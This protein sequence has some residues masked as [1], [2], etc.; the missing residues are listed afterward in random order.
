V[1]VPNK[2]GHPSLLPSCLEQALPLSSKVDQADTACQAL[3]KKLQV[4][5][6]NNKNR[7]SRCRLARDS[8]MF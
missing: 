4:K 2:N 8:R 6:Q 5:S 7:T 1:P 3:N